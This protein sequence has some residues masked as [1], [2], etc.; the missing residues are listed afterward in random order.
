MY[1]QSNTNMKQVS[2]EIA[3]KMYEES[4]TQADKVAYDIAKKQLESSFDLEKSIGFNDFLKRENIE[5]I[6]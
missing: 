1:N 3:F 2:K 6:D 4:M 5:I